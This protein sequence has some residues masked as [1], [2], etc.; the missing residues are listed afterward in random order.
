MIRKSFI[1]LERVGL[2]KEKSIWKEAE[3]WDDFLKKGNIK[4]IS[5]MKKGFYDRQ[6]E[7]ASF[8]LRND[9]AE[10]FKNI[11]PTTE[12]WR[13]YNHFKNEAVYLDIETN[14]FSYPTVVGLYDGQNMKSFVKGINL[15]ARKL[16]EELSKYK[17]ILTFNGA[18]F[19]LPVLNRYYPGCIPEIPHIDLRHVCARINLKGGLKMIE[20]ELGIRRPKHL[21]GMGGDHAVDLWR[22]WLASG[23]DEYLD[24]LIQYNEQDVLNLEPL[25]NIAT[26]RM[27][28]TMLREI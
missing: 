16:K 24:L 17:L 1:I 12:T 22:A 18:S 8:E 27:E 14:D 28:E 11:L 15:D 13:L 4:G 25:A 20:T 9:N 26:Q 21:L 3:S 5:R 2:Q 7:K 6:L 23:D 19:D 10:Y